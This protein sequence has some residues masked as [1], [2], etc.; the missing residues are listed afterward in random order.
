MEDELDLIVVH[1]RLDFKRVSVAEYDIVIPAVDLCLSNQIYF[2]P[3]SDARFS[4][5]THYGTTFREM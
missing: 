2:K 1:L 4:L 3:A 5:D